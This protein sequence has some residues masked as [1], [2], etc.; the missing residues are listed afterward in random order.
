MATKFYFCPVCGNVV[1][2]MVDS[3]VAPSCC[4]RTMEELAPHTQEEA[5]GQESHLPVVIRVDVYNVKVAVGTKM[6]PSLPNH[7]IEFLYLQT[8]HGGRIHFLEPTEEPCATFCCLGTPIAAYAY[9][10]I[11]GLW[12]T[13]VINI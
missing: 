8:A 4:G 13:D 2:K 1:M 7:H 9:C 12:K 10:N 3:G 11:H 6:H 5:N